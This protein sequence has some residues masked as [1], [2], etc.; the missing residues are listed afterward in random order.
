MP[1]TEMT[2][3][4]LHLIIKFKIDGEKGLRVKGA[5]RIRVDGSGLTIIE[6]HTGAVETLPR[7]R[8]E[9]L[10]IQSVPCPYAA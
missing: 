4:D 2:M 1:N 6:P 7:G 5:A 3:A 8:I 9:V 10:S